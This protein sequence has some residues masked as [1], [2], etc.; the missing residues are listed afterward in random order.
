[1]KI[2]ILTRSFISAIFSSMYVHLIFL[3]LLGF[4]RLAESIPVGDWPLGLERD[5]EIPIENP[6]TEEKVRLGKRLFFDKK[7]SRS[8]V[9]SCATCH[10]PAQG[11]SNGSVVAKGVSG[12]QGSRNVPTLVN[13]IYGKSQFWDGRVQTLESQ[14]LMP[15]FNPHEMAMNENLL[16]QRL[17]TDPIYQKLFEEAFGTPIPT[18]DSISKAIACFERTLLTGDSPFDQY[19]WE[20]QQAALSDSA[21]RGLRLFRGKARCST[22]HIGTN[23]TDEKFHNIGA[24]TGSGQIDAGREAVTEDPADLGKFKTPSLRNVELTAPYM[25]DGSLARLE[26][27]IEFYDQGGRPNPNLDPEMKPLELSNTEKSD[28][29][30]FLKSLTGPIISVNIEEL[31]VLSESRH[32]H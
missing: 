11:F 7:L 14:V 1:M 21:A 29:L 16:L 23:F 32:P 26:D 24:G 22:C 31:K 18:V 19:E 3:F 10:D 2:T 5:F 20:G 13:R 6:L 28:L 12:Q 15:L 4:S 30:A 8:Q 27:V 9:L 17:Q 25:H